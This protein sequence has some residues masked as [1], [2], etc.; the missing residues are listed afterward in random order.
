[1]PERTSYEPGTFS[2]VDIA[3][4]D[5]EAAKSFY[6]GIFGWEYDTQ[7]SPVG[8]YVMALKN[9]QAVAGMGILPQDQQ[10]MGVPSMWSSYVSVASADESAAK[11]A[12]LGGTVMMPPMD[13]MDAGRM[14]FVI[15]PGGEM[16]GLWE[17]KNH[18]G[19]GLVGEHG[20]VVWNEL[21]TRNLEEAS[22]FY[23]NLFGWTVTTGPVAGTD[24]EYSVATVGEAMAS[25]LMTMGDNWPAEV[26]PH[27]VVYFEVDD[28]EASAAAAK[29][30][31]GTVVV[32]PMTVEG[33]GTFA[34]IQ[35]PTGATCSIMTS[36]PM[37]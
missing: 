16:F 34:T 8:P 7:D 32:P 4:S 6:A 12:E 26:P 9:G 33:V 35:D 14:A 36:A 25:G 24:M 11:A 23:S 13:A 30:L 22:G 5:L 20:S 31:G 10:D 18:I 37:E 3:T 28:C 29:D 21:A 17:A 2:W 27:W 15:A 19:A 1:M